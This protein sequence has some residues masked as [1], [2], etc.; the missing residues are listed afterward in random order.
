MR[1]QQPGVRDTFTPPQ[2]H[3]NI[4]VGRQRAE[5]LKIKRLK[6]LIQETHKDVPTKADGKDGSM[7]IHHVLM[8][9]RIGLTCGRDFPLPPL[10]SK[11]SQC[12]R[13]VGCS[14]KKIIADSSPGASLVLFCSAKFIKVGRFFNRTISR[15]AHSQSFGVS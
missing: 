9:C 12:V 3:E 13:G 1:N 4:I 6:M 7:S 10:Y 15:R 8:A 14:Y 2:R 5:E 11:L